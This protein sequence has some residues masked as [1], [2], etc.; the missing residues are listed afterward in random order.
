MPAAPAA[1]HSP[2]G[3]ASCVVSGISQSLREADA[4]HP[5]GY[6]TDRYVWSLISGVG[7][8]FLGC[9][10][11]TYHGIAGIFSPHE[12]EH[13]EIGVGVL[14]LAFVVEGYSLVVALRECK[15]EARKSGVRSATDWA[16]VSLN[17]CNWIHSC[18][19]GVRAGCLMSCTCPVPASRHLTQCPRGAQGRDTHDSSTR[20][21]RTRTHT[22]TGARARTHSTLSRG[23]PSV[24]LTSAAQPVA[25][26]AAC[27]STS[28]R[29][30]TP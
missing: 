12:I 28:W 13:F 20:G 21:T 26:A 10:V 24:P 23:T 9:G 15:H 4:S 2:D 25:P 3:C 18:L 5:Y 30:L 8:F 27:G 11:S 7:I 29:A 1:A 16:L 19:L 14:A 17:S 6:A 22:H